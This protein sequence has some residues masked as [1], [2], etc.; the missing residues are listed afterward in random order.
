MAAKIVRTGEEL[1][2]GLRN[3]PP[4]TPDDVTILWDGRRIDSREAAL[5][6]L[7]EMA[8]ERAATDARS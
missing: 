8:A 3:A 6:W 4:A 5:A 7:A 2:E 1:A